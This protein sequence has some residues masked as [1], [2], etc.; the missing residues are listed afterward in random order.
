MIKIR[1]ADLNDLPILLAFEQEVIATERP[2]DIDLRRDEISYYDIAALIQ[3]EHAAMLVAEEDGHIVGCGYAKIQDSKPW[4]VYDQH[5][6]LGFMYTRP[7]FRGRGI[8]KLI[9]EA[10][11]EWTKSKGVNHVALEVYESN[12]PAIRAYEKVGFDKRLIEMR[13]KL[14]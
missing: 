9:M 2:M 11:F 8:N 1:H 4:H 14:D 6:Y 10:L 3:S 13:M 5:S 7:E 12:F